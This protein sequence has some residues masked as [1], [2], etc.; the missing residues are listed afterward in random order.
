MVNEGPLRELGRIMATPGAQAKRPPALDPDQT[1]P[2]DIAAEMPQAPR[3]PINGEPM[4]VV[5]TPPRPTGANRNESAPVA[6]PA[7]EPSVSEPATPAAKEADDIPKWMRGTLDRNKILEDRA[8]QLERDALQLR[9]ENEKLR[10][11]TAYQQVLNAQRPPG[12]DEWSGEQQS[13]WL[14]QQ[15][16]RTQEDRIANLEQRYQQFEAQQRDFLLRSSLDGLNEQQFA[17]VRVTMSEKGLA[18]PQDGLAIAAHRY[19]EL[20]TPQSP[21]Q[22]APPATVSPQSGDRAAPRGA[23]ELS[24]DERILRDPGSSRHERLVAFGRMQAR[25]EG[26]RKTPRGGSRRI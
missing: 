15:M 16:Q 5:E 2:P 25:G 7:P 20:F 9:E 13:A 12:Y 3:S 11:E 17:A 1:A 24:E 6:T 23:D 10:R 19:P 22:P 26:I 4:E 14:A 18:D 21:Q 8:Q